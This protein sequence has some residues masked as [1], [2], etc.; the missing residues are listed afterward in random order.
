[1]ID[2]CTKYITENR[3][4]ACSQC[5]DDYYLFGK[6]CIVRDAS[7]TIEGCDEYSFD[8][9]TCQECDSG[10]QL[11]TDGLKCLDEIEHC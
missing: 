1:M 11:T 9:D 4:P 5:E 3:K 8:S 10:K 6:Q 7:A 2:K